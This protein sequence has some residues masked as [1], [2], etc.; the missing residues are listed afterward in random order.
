MYVSSLDNFKAK[1]VEGRGGGG[2]GEG[3]HPLV[4]GRRG[5]VLSL[6]NSIGDLVAVYVCMHACKHARICR[7]SNPI[8]DI[9][10]SL[11]FAELLS[12]TRQWPVSTCDLFFSGH[13]ALL[14][15]HL[16]L[17]VV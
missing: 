9:T 15:H 10:L 12:C 13:T 6:A 3:L 1:M 14:S 11:Q 5:V 17:P 4:P 8:D 16:P 2:W 7:S